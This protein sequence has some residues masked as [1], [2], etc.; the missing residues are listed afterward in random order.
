MAE[1][2]VLLCWSRSLAVMC[3]GGVVV[4]DEEGRRRERVE[5]GVFIDEDGASGGGT[6]ICHSLAVD[7]HFGGV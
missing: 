2:V 3:R 1:A 7:V 4:G 6:V 5:E